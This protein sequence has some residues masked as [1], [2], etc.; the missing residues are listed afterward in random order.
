MYKLDFLKAAMSSASTVS[1]LEINENFHQIVSFMENGE[2]DSAIPLLENA[3]QKNVLDIRLI[4][5][6]LH[7]NFV[8]GGIKT[9]SD[10]LPILLSLMEE[11]WEKLSPSTK[12]EKQAEKSFAWFFSRQIKALEGANRA[13]KN[14]DAEPLNKFTTGMTADSLDKMGEWTTKLCQ[15]FLVRWP[16]G[17]VNNQLL[18]MMKSARE[19][20]HLVFKTQEIKTEKKAEKEEK[21]AS[22]ASSIKKE[23]NKPL[24]GLLSIPVNALEPS[25]ALEELYKKIQAFKALVERKDYHKAVIVTGDIEQRLENFNPALYFPKLFIEYYSLYAKHASQLEDQRPT[26]AQKLLQKLFEAD[27]DSFVDW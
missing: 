16:S 22:P 1:D 17:Q 2:F 15:I 10:T 5:Y 11:S 8:K 27:L 9:L 25:P 21:L 14:N 19:L 13:Y 24:N 26:N 3:F 12:R 18:H 23:E 4:L 7:A 6:F 20:S